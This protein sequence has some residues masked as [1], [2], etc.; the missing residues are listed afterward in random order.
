LEVKLLTLL[1]ETMLANV[2][3]VVIG[4]ITRSQPKSLKKIKK[5]EIYWFIYRNGMININIY[6]P[7]LFVSNMRL[8]YYL[9]QL[10]Y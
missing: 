1:Q 10:H 7:L 2:S 8:Y 5:K 4:K 9:L 6:L 3:D